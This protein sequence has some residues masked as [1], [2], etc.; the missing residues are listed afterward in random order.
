MRAFIT[1]GS[2]FVG[3]NLSRALIREGHQVTILSRSE[4]PAKSQQ[5]GVSVV[6]GDPARPGKWQE[7]V[8]GHDLL[9]NLAGA[10]IFKR[11]DARYKQLLRD[12]RM[13][14]TRNLVDAIPEGQGVTLLSTSAVGYYGFTGDE[15]LDENSPP[16]TD[17]LARLARDWE[18]EALRARERGA[19]VV[20][21]RFGVVLGRDGGALEQMI[22]P[23]RFFV[24]G[25]LGRGEQWFSWIHLNDLC[26]A[27]LFAVADPRIEGP[28][29]F[30]APGLVRNREL[31]RAIGKVTG[32]PSFMP[33]PGFMI[34]LIL[35]EFGTVI[36]KGQRVLPRALQ[37]KGFHFSFP[38]MESALRDLLKK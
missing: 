37:A 23:F 30:T 36:L 1:G 34:S 14:T 9:I 22:M 5:P 27:A 29:N 19:R 25:P 20:I 15:E 31:A 33:A 24:G 18:A 7:S 32:R 3:S 8:S 16:G 28:L 11:W 21:M 6:A 38:D 12:S 26:E 2:G 13:L 35:G 10:S 4:K 17:F